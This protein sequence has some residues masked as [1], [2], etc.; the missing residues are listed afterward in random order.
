VLDRPELVAPDAPLARRALRALPSVLFYVAVAV[1]AWFI[2]PT[3]LGG[4]T[5]LTLVS[6]HSMEP[7]YVTG[8]IVVARCGQPA[9][10]DV[11]VY[12][13]DEVAGNSRIIHRVVGGTADGWVM[14]G[15]NNEFLDPFE[16]AGD[17]VLGVARVHIP[18]VGLVFQTFSN[19]WVWIA[20]IALA[21]AM[22]VWPSKDE[23]DDDLDDDD[24]DELPSDDGPSDEQRPDTL[25]PDELSPHE[26]SPHEL[27]PHEQSPDEGW[28]LL[29]GD[30]GRAPDRAPELEPSA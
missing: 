1:I 13:P 4:C 10:G 14:Q 24:R 12:A 23:S 19:A 15:D 8:D 30:R 16:P 29:G 22:L 21:L 5:T 28:D 26:L 27:S 6:G 7:T 9:V 17:E 2:W 25:S 11:I 18:K 3:S 20:M